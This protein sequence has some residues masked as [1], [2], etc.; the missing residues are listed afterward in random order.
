VSETSDIASD[1]ILSRSRLVYTYTERNDNLR[2]C[3]IQDILMYAFLND[4]FDSEHIKC[5]ADI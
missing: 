4:A 2:L 1:I 5:L 3:V